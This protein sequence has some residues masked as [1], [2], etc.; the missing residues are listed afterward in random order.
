LIGATGSFTSPDYPNP[1]PHRREC[2]WT[3]TVATGMSVELTI[4]DFDLESHSECR[5]DVLEV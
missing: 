2:I 4:E 5:Y 3:I 1:Y